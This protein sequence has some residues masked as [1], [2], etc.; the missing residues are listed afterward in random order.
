MRRAI[1]VTFFLSAALTL[2]PL[3]RAQRGTA[4]ADMFNTV[5]VKLANGEQVVGGTVDTADPDKLRQ[6]I[7]ASGDHVE[8]GLRGI[9]KC[10]EHTERFTVTSCL[11]GTLR[12]DGDAGTVTGLSLRTVAGCI[13]VRRSDGDGYVARNDIIFEIATAEK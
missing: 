8:I 9:L 11:E 13:H 3:A 7:S 2:G 12:F 5:K 4:A 1:L 6:V 10:G